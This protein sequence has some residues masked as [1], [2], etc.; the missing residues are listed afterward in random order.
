MVLAVK[1]TLSSIQT[2]NSGL[3]VMLTVAFVPGSMTV[4]VEEHVLI[5]PASSS[6]VNVIELTPISAQV[7]TV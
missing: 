6:T 7:N 5:L 3:E 4:T 1:V 2:G